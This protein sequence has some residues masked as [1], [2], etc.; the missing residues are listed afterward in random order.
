M[1]VFSSSCFNPS[2][3]NLQE[4]SVKVEV[5]QALHPYSVPLSTG[6]MC[7]RRGESDGNIPSI[8]VWKS[9]FAVELTTLSRKAQSLAHSDSTFPLQPS[10]VNQEERQEE[11]GVK[12]RID[13]T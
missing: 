2:I 8:S 13:Q 11:G 10:D 9:C 6:L 5:A 4:V 1:L 7:F 12:V 3:D